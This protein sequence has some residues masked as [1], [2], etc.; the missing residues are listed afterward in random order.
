MDVPK[1]YISKIKIPVPGD[2][3]AF[4]GVTRS[5]MVIGPALQVTASGGVLEVTLPYKATHDEG[6][7]NLL[8]TFEIDGEEFNRSLDVNV[9]T[10]YIELHEIKDILGDAADDQECFDAEAAA[11][12]IINAHTGQEFGLFVG[13]VKVLSNYDEALPLPRRL[14]E[15]T[16]IVAGTIPIFDRDTPTSYLNFLGENQFVTTGSG[17]FLKRPIWSSSIIVGDMYS[18][19]PIEAPRFTGVHKFDNDVEYT[20]T[21]KFG[22]ESVPEPV[23]QAAK[24]LTEQYECADREYREQ[25][26][27]SIKSADWR[28]QFNSG[29]YRRTGNARAD[30]LL[31]PYV[32]NRAKVI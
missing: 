10:P 9:V 13:T 12:Q 23:R 5:D 8:V 28:I 14:I 2:V 22:Y 32:I 25:Y 20:I 17:W 24:I 15:P 16:K 26:L 3:D 18:S 21:G 4:I 29:A 31:S 19:D 7:V 27:E 6:V 11:R 30:K 1:G